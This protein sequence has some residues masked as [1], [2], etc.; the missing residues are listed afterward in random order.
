MDYQKMIEDILKTDAFKSL[1]T[2]ELVHKISKEYHFQD[3]EGVLI[4]RE[5]REI[6]KAEA[7][8]MV[9]EVVDDYFELHDTKTLLEREINKLS[10]SEII[11]LLIIKLKK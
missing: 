11:D 1:L 4:K 10:R 2:E 6:I 3:I 9:K 7:E 8:N 5:V